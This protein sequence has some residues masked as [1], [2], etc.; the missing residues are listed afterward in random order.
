M[1]KRFKSCA[2]TVAAVIGIASV[3]AIAPSLCVRSA[4]AQDFPPRQ[5]SIVVGFPAGGGT[6]LIARLIAQKMSAGLGVNVIVENRPGAA[7]TIGTSAVARS[8][9]TGQT[10]LFTPSNIAM[11]RAI[12]ARLPFDPQQDLAPIALTTSIPFVLVV[13]PSLSVKT[14]KDLVALAKRRPGALDYGSSGPGS[15]PYFAMELLKARADID[16]KEI[17]YKGAGGI[18]TGLLGGEVQTSFLIPPLAR[19]HIQSGKM[20]GLAVSTRT[21]SS[22]LPELPTLV[23]VGFPDYEITQWHAFFAPANTPAKVIDGL[24]S[25]INRLLA[26]PDIG[27][28]LESEG[29]AVVR[30]TPQQLASHLAAEIKAYTDLAQRLKLKIE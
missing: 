2:A 16:I 20:R 5:V 26:L 6:D 28:R 7:G 21:R 9:P 13:H 23:E 10:L 8:A 29:A 17:S 4:Q 3:G 24:N 12:Y 11:T 19:L 27:K 1:N 30:S 15:P 18:I 22:A 14:A 25:E